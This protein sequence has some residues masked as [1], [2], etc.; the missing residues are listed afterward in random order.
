[1]SGNLTIIMQKA[2]EISTNS[3]SLV[4][5]LK[6]LIMSEPVT[7]TGA[8]IDPLVFAITIFTLACFIGYY[9]VWKVTPALHTPLMSVTNAISGVVVIGSMLAASF[10]TWNLASIIG[11]AAVFLAS[12]NIFGGFI[13]TKRMLGMFSK[14]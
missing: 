3:Q 14:R 8:H 10:D 11:L 13:V 2:N 4:D 9:V 12:V 6:D 5:R 1:M 7:H